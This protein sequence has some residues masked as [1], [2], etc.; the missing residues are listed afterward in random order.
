MQMYKFNI[1]GFLQWG[2]NFYNNQWSTDQINPYLECGANLIFTGGDP[3]SVYP[4]PDG[5]ALESARIIVFHE[6]LQDIKAMKLCEK[7]YGHDRVVAEIEN[8]LG[9]EL[10][11]ERCALS[12][13]EM[14]LVRE[15]INQLIK[16]AL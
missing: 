3:F 8:V 15:R 1:E 6:A 10:T 14:L 7:Y 13:H 16:K 2:Y 5:T 4:A 9:D 12:S 11:F